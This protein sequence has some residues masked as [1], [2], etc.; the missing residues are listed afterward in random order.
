MG[1]SG[2]PEILGKPDYS[3]LA[4]SG[5]QVA[6][7]NVDAIEKSAKRLIVSSFRM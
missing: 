5:V 2:S 3:L 4:S 7:F 1:H 6:A